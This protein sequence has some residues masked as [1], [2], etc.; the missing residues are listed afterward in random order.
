MKKLIQSAFAL[1]V[2]SVAMTACVS[3][4]V[5]FDQ[6]KAPEGEATGFVSFGEEGITVVTDSEIVRAAAPDVNTFTCTILTNGGEEVQSFTYGDRPTSPIELKTGSYTLKVTSASTIPDAEW[7]TPVYG[8]EVPFTITKDATTTLEPVKCKL[9]NIKVTVEYAADLAAVLQ[10]GSQTVVS[11]GSAAKTFGYADGNAEARAAYFKAAAASNTLQVDMSIVVADKLSKM[12]H[13]INGV[14]PGQWRKLTI[15]MPH[16]TEGNATF[17]ITIE[18]LTADEEIVVDVAEVTALSEEVIPD[19]PVVDPLAPTVTWAGHDLK[20]TTQLIAA[21]FNEDGECTLPSNI[22]VATKE[23]ATIQSLAV[24]ISSTSSSLIDELAGMNVTTSFDLCEVTAASNRKL[25]IGL[26]SLG[27][28]TGADV[29]GQATVTFDLRAAM[30]TLY[31]NNG[32]HEFKFT[33]TDHLGHTGD[34][35]LSILVDKNHEDGVFGPVIEWVGNDISVPHVVTEGLEVKI[36]VSTNGVGI[37]GFTV[38]IVSDV[39]TAEA[40]G[41][42]LPTHLDLVNPG[43]FGDKLVGLGFPVKEAVTNAENGEL[44]FDITDFMPAL[45]GVANGEKCYA[46]FV[47]NVTDNNGVTT[48]ATLQLLINQ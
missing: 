30:P 15:S 14:K 42:L 41:D 20:E 29:K 28:L 31:A 44:N 25:N 45:I 46:N 38:D 48:E 40:L 21:M 24:E 1:F 4:G 10:N 12:T 18:T 6:P 36:K 23:G 27:F 47:M 13:N 2:A 8:A 9:S 26:K 16:A 35:V 7:E 32:T 17:I 11:L 34:A 43:E 19:D 22:V 5:E 33:I 3:D 37:S 39:L